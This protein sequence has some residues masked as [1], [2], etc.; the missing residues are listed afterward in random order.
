MERTGH[1][2]LGVMVEV[3]FQDPN[4]EAET[5]S[6]EVRIYLTNGAGG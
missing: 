2:Q 4:A 5:G 3:I 6:S 1:L